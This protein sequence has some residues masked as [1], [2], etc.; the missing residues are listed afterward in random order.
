MNTKLMMSNKDEN[1]DDSTDETIIIKEGEWKI[2]TYDIDE[3]NKLVGQINSDGP[4]NIYIV[5]NRN[6]RLFE[7]DD[8]FTEED[9][10]E[11]AKRYKINFQPPRAGTWNIVIE[12]AEDVDAEVDVFLDVK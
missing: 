7:D 1:N 3:N 9:G 4:V 2:Y 11:N 12:N 10:I 5:N 6:L 8:D